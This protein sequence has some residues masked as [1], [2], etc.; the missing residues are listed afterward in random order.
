MAHVAEPS[1][2]GICRRLAAGSEMSAAV[3][4]LTDAADCFAAGVFRYGNTRSSIEA[5]DR[6]I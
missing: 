6:A 4:A 2:D 3:D 5:S 1:A